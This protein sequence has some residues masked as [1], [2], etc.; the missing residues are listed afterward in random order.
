MNSKLGAFV[1]RSYPG[2]LEAFIDAKPRIVKTINSVG[3]AKVL[4]DALGPQ[5]V[6]IAR[7][8]VQGDDFI[9]AHNSLGKTDP[10]GEAYRWWND[11]KAHV[12]EAPFAYWE[13]Y[14][15]MSDWDFMRQYNVFET[16]RQRIMY[17]EGMKACVGNFAA[18]TPDITE[19]DLDIERH[20]DWPIFYPMLEACNRYQNILG[21][22]EYASLWLSLWMGA[23][24]QHAPILARRTATF[25]E[26]HE[27]GW[28]FGRYRKL[29]RRHIAPMGWT[30]IRIALTEFGWDRAGVYTTDYL[31][32]GANAGPW[33][34]VGKY[35]GALDG[36]PDTE[37][38]AVD[39]LRWA[40]RQ[41]QQDDY[42]V[43]ATIFCWGT[44]DPVWQYW[45]VKG[46]VG[47][48][49]LKSM[50]EH[51][52][53]DNTK[54]VATRKGLNMRIHPDI[55]SPILTTLPFNQLVSVEGPVGEWSYVKSGRLTGWVKSQFLV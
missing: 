52:L 14:N 25:P 4:Y 33:R 32:G 40:D 38:Y 50:K 42:L 16:E 29:W 9:H 31:T 24:N 17:N 8:T 21:L 44:D 7:T 30:R 12:Q 47:D 53:P 2:Q 19:S 48:A 46:G 10:I 6:F 45:D 18:G 20:D 11:V 28:L 13:S 26:S 15:E 5:T 49:L 35:W 41:M 39:Q 22:H 51:P 36:R 27:E 23:E 34:Q 3:D 1:L 55:N 37:S 43:G 54:V